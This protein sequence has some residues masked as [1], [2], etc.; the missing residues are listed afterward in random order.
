MTKAVKSRGEIHVA[1]AAVARERTRHENDD[2]EKVAAQPNLPGALSP[3]HQ[4]RSGPESTADQGKLC[5]DRGLRE[6][7]DLSYNRVPFDFDSEV[8]GSRPQTSGPRRVDSK[9]RGAYM[10]RRVFI[11]SLTLAS[12]ACTSDLSCPPGDI[13]N[14]AGICETPAVDS[15]TNAATARN[16]SASRDAA[17]DAPSSQVPVGRDGD[18]SAELSVSDAASD[19]NDA[20]LDA[21]TDAAEVDAAEAAGDVAPPDAAPACVPSAEICNGKDDDCDTFVDEDV[22]QAPI[23]ADC[24]AGQ[25]ACKTPGKHVCRNGAPVCDAVP[26]QGSAEVC[27]NVDNDCD[28]TADE[29]PT[30][31]TFGAACSGGEGACNVPGTFVCSGGKLTCSAPVMPTAEICDNVDNDCDGTADESFTNKGKP[32]PTPTP[33]DCQGTGTW[34]CDPADPTKL[35]CNAVEKPKTCGSSCAP[36]PTKECPEGTGECKSIEPW[37]CDEA[38]S[39]WLCPAVA[40]APAEIC[41][42]GKDNDC[43]GMIDENTPTWYPDC[44]LDGVPSIENGVAACTKPTPADCTSWT[45]QRPV[46][47]DCNDR[48]RRYSPSVP[49]FQSGNAPNAVEELSYIGDMDC[50]GLIEKPAVWDTY[51]DGQWQPGPIEYANLPLCPSDA[52]AC[53]LT[54]AQVCYQNN[55]SPGKPLDCGNTEITVLGTD[56]HCFLHDHSVRV[57][58]R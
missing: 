17:L 24:S 38:S 46:L 55:D 30:D 53:G 40:K 2:L 8:A 13:E 45:D 7:P 5:V 58:C 50:D 51:I 4:G 39:V 56:A 34:E 15:G 42:D 28:G 16:G 29:E 36:R 3:P 21:E 57:I 49:V 44:D 27:D 48:D 25:G 41:G 12:V 18:G 37:A 9:Y 47:S 23:G 52:T 32:C 31:A 20:V 1:R 43:D 11:S 22:S 26:G 35:R 14:E 19:A 54:L 33:G 6:H 10:M